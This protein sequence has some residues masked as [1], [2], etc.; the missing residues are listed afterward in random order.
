MEKGKGTFW[1]KRDQFFFKK[2]LY[3][4]DYVIYNVFF[5]TERGNDDVCIIIP[6]LCQQITKSVLF[7]DS[8]DVVVV[9]VI[10]VVNKLAVQT[11]L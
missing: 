9:E 11:I 4:E 5:V 3:V 8:H 6:F 7:L 1:T 2:F 10:T